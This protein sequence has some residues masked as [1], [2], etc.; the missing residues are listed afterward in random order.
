MKARHDPSTKPYYKC[1]CC[2]QFRH[3]CAG[4]PTRDMSLQEWCEYMRDTMD[5][6]HL[7][8]PYVAKEAGVSTKTIERIRATCVDNDFMRETARKVESAVI[9]KITNV[10]CYVDCDDSEQVKTLKAEIEYW[11][12]ENDR[13]AKIIDMYLEG[14]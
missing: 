5:I 6:A 14:K 1:L 7:P 11:R 13:K 12:K 3:N 9:G 10:Q 2:P 8:N 4:L